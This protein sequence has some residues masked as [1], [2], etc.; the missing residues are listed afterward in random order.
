MTLGPGPYQAYRARSLSWSDE[1]PV[2]RGQ[3]GRFVAAAHAELGQDRGDVVADRLLGD[4]EPRG[5]L[6]VRQALRDE[7]EHFCLAACEPR[8]MLPGVRTRAAGDAHATLPELPR[9]DR[10]GRTRAELN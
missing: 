7:L 6:G 2:F 8:R 10:R 4:E 3:L 9:H 1:L 5:D